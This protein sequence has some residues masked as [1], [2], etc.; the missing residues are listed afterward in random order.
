[1]ARSDAEALRARIR[2]ARAG[3]A[4]AELELAAA[5]EQLS[6]REVQR[7]ARALANRRAY[8]AE[9]VALLRRPPPG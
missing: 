6:Y 8:L 4:E 2:R 5:R 7:L 1:M 3:I 9:L